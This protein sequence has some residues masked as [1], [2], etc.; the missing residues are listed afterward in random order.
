[1]KSAPKTNAI[2][3][4]DSHKVEYEVRTY[5]AA[6]GI[7]D[8]VGVARKVG[9]DP[10]CLF[11]TLVARASGGIAAGRIF[12]FCVPGACELNLNHA[13]TVCRSRSVELVGV[14]ELLGLTGYIR[15][16]C[17]PL[18]MKRPYPLFVERTATLCDRITISGGRIGIQVSVEPD[19]LIAVTGG[20]YAD[21]I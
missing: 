8:A 14:N 15:G 18:G 12:V 13:A 16:G 4:L 9:V 21:L 19:A 20:Q 5:E 17:S 10:D 7:I 1:M 2:R 3:L 6:D 11:K